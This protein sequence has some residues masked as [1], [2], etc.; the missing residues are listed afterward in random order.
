MGSDGERRVIAAAGDDVPGILPA[1]YV[2]FLPVLERLSEPLMRV[3][4]GQL[5]QFERL[6]SNFDTHEMTAQGEFEGLGG[7][8]MRGEIAHILQSELLLRTE[9]PLEF[10]RR[11]VESET[12]FLEKQYADPGAKSV[13]RA[14]ISVGPGLLGHGRIIALAAI[15]FL[16]RIARERGAAFHWS[17]LP[18][19]EGPIWFNEVSVNTVKRFLRAAS[20]REMHADDLA[21]AEAIWDRL[22]QEDRTNG[23]VR[24]VD[25][26]IG[27]AGTRRLRHGN[28]TVAVSEASNSLAFMLL[29]PARDVPRSA[30]IAVRHL[31]RERASATIVFPDDASCASAL[32]NPFRPLRPQVLAGAIGKA[33]PERTGWEPLHF[34]APNNRTRI[35]RLNDGLLVLD[36]IT[37]QQTGHSYFVVIPQEMHL[38]GLQADG[39]M[40]SLIVHSSLRERERLSYFRIFPMG[41]PKVT[42][43]CIRSWPVPSEHLFHKRSPAALPPLNVGRDVEF[44]SGSGQ[45]YRLRLNS[46]DWDT[47][48][49]PQ[50]DAPKTLFANGTHRIVFANREDEPVLR[51]QKGTKQ[52]VD[53]FLL[54]PGTKP[55]Q[56]RD[57]VYWGTDRGLAYSLQPGLWTVPAALGSLAGPAG[58]LQVEP[59]EKVLSATRH[60]DVVTARIWSDA[61]YG[62][63]GSVR[64]IRIEN[65]VR[66]ARNL[67]V[68]LGDDA[69]SIIKVLQDDDGLWA[70][71]TDGAGN[72]AELLQ[73]RLQ[74]RDHRYQC[75]RFD[76]RKLRSKATQ[77]RLETHDG[78]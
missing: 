23:I 56:V 58:E 30:Q 74:K 52:G 71:T 69:F 76:L 62:G 5:L 11:L 16:A 42:L 4:E 38:A 65:G 40:L 27:A 36:R 60:G 34:I 50:Y 14:T 51:V 10:L 73:Y 55:E 75:I 59:Y 21:E 39:T 22:S 49:K 2:P 13:Y 37:K 17:I 44:Y 48:F 8:T 41:V 24:H 63:D 46:E 67:P 20:H 15:F 66:T 47:G 6:A 61:R 64:A 31:G 45:A 68:K 19:R 77:L 7:L 70:L 57:L 1:V 9:A 28:A 32:E 72:P 53:D 35:I 18:R 33:I 54:P 3:I 29:P 12:V 43:E 78:E 25:W 26:A